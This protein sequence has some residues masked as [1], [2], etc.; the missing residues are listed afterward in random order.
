ML[1]FCDKLAYTAGLIVQIKLRFQTS[2]AERGQRLIVVN[3]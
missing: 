2:P 1:Y 3:F